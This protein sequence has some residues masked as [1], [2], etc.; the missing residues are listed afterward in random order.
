MLD[1]LRTE[2]NRKF[3]SGPSRRKDR[4]SQVPYVYSVLFLIGFVFFIFHGITWVIPQLRM[5]RDSE[6]GVC[7]VLETRIQEK[8]NE[9]ADTAGNESLYRPEVRIAFEVDN[10]KYVLWTYDSETLTENGGFSADRKLVEKIVNSFNI[11]EQY[12]FW[13]NPFDPEKAVLIRGTSIWGWYFLAIPICLMVFGASGLYLSFRNFYI[14]EERK[15]AILAKKA[16]PPLALLNII[17]ASMPGHNPKF[18]TVP[19]SKTINDSPGTFLAFR[20]PTAWQPS[21]RLFTF[22][23]YVVIWNVIAWVTLTWNLYHTTGTRSDLFFAVTFGVLFCGGGLVLIIWVLHHILKVFGVHPPI[24][25][26]SDHP[27]YPGRKYRIMLVL[28]GA[29][30]IRKLEVELVCMEIARFRQGTDTITSRREVYHQPLFFRED[31]ETTWNAALQQE[32]FVRLPIGAMH[33]V[34][35]EHNEIVWMLVL[36]TDL[37]GWSNMRCECPII[38]NPVGITERSIE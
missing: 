15:A 13:Y 33:S 25:E 28:S 34:Q 21:V 6:P 7:T 29:L 31:F 36:K 12:Q 5:L 3:G 24:L 8:K 17:P 1:R 20:L 9:H 14:S 26:I 23:V 22:A 11:N 4:A 10:V 30:R 35:L 27:I 2:L 32:F 18:P 37:I 19:D 16:S 38:V